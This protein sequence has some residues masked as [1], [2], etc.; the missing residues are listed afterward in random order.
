MMSKFLSIF[1]MTCVTLWASQ[2]IAQGAATPPQKSAKKT[3]AKKAPAATEPASAADDD[4]NEPDTNGS[5]ISE[6]H[7]ELGNKVTIYQNVEDGKHI[8]LRWLKRIHQLARVDT[9][10]GAD[11][12]ENR[13]TG[14]VWIGIPAKGMLLDSKKGQQLANEC[15]TAEQ[16]KPRKPDVPELLTSAEVAKS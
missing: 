1:L 6:F 4:G 14:L 8:A 11:R 7:C 13:K 15:R 2:A 10:T 16:M 5:L 9:T 3:P 12:F